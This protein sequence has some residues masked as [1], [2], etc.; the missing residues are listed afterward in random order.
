M[1]SS[2]TGTLP[3]RLYCVKTRTLVQGNTLP[4]STSYVCGSYTWSTS[5][6]EPYSLATIPWRIASVT[7]SQIHEFIKD[8]EDRDVHYLWLDILC[9]NQQSEDDK[10]QEV[11]AM[12]RYYRNCKYALV[13]L[14]DQARGPVQLDGT[15]TPWFHR[16]W[17][18]QESILPPALCFVRFDG[19][20]DYDRQGARIGAVAFASRLLHTSAVFEEKM[21]AFQVCM[22]HRRPGPAMV[23]QCSLSRLALRDED[24]VYGALGLLEDWMTGPVPIEYG[25]GMAEALR[26]V[27]DRLTPEAVGAVAAV[28]TDPIFPIPTTYAP[29]P[30][31]SYMISRMNI[32]ISGTYRFTRSLTTSALQ[33]TFKASLTPWK[34]IAPLCDSVYVP[35]QLTG[36][37]DLPRQAVAEVAQSLDSWGSQMHSPLLKFFV[38]KRTHLWKVP[39]EDKAGGVTSRAASELVTAIRSNMAFQR[40]TF[41]AMSVQEL[42]NLWK[43]VPSAAVYDRGGVVTASVMMEEDMNL[44]AV[45]TNE[46]GWVVCLVVKAVADEEG[47]WE[48]IGAAIIAPSLSFCGEVV[49]GVIG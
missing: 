28:L 13:W 2:S 36:S 6:V 17:T 19:Y 45:G 22:G 32:T 37:P 18:F 3:T 29:S 33:V 39:P 20:N 48:K 27:L 4:P 1:I 10:A 31:L 24:R 9:I 44:L 15:P 34:R 12:G 40:G 23:I 43:A 21:H 41:T 30:R 26:R 46:S 47:L 7:S 38:G 8:A 35:A 49:D 25:I 42:S 14:G 16:A 11:T 5:P